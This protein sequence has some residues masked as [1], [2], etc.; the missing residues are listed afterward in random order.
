MN[1]KLSDYD[2]WTANVRARVEQANDYDA[3]EFEI[4]RPDEDA[5]SNVVL[6]VQR[7]DEAEEWDD[8][9][10]IRFLNGVLQR[11]GFEAITDGT[12]PVEGV[13]ILPREPLDY[14]F[15]DDEEA[16]RLVGEALAAESEE[17]RELE[18]EE[19]PK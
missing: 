8:D 4:S 9:A 3:D 12:R 19:R 2:Y 7:T 17:R 5:A 11:A 13:H 6:H 1:E 14:P 10:W 16:E 15:I 18:R